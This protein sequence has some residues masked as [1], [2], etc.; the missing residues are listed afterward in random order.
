[1]SELLIP[2]SAHHAGTQEELPP[3]AEP[4]APVAKTATN[5]NARKADPRIAKTNDAN[6]TG[7]STGV[8]LE[9]EAVVKLQDQWVPSVD[10]SAVLQ[11]VDNSVSSSPALQEFA[12][13]AEAP[14]VGP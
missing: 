12:A 8:A 11:P 4:K 3:I 7:S 2:S 6:G 14:N 1:M 10:E 9:P 13:P 5:I